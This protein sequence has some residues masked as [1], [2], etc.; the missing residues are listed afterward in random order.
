MG[1]KICKIC[2]IE[3]PKTKF[4]FNR[5]G[6]HNDI[7]RECS[8]AKRRQTRE[9][10]RA[11]LHNGM[12]HYHDPDFEDKDPVDV[13]QFMSRAKRWLESRGYEISLSGYYNMR[14]PIK[15]Q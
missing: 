13:I 11:V 8:A 2:G 14:K 6:Q 15:F 1:T 5:W 3:K 10:N 9:T 4:P 7:C 12:N